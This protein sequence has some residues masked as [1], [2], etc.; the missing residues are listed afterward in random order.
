ML[1]GTAGFNHGTGGEDTADITV[2]VCLVTQVF[3]SLG[4]SLADYPCSGIPVKNPYHLPRIAIF[5]S[6]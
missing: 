2:K 3:E 6:T 1:A 5:F 4:I